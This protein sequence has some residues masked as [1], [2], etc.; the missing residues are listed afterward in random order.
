MQ[1]ILTVSQKKKK[2]III[3]HCEMFLEQ[4]IKIKITMISL[5]TE[6]WNNGCRKFS[7]AIPEIN[8]ILNKY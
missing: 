8:K 7:F 3:I 6:Y 4:K 2:N 5:D 1:K